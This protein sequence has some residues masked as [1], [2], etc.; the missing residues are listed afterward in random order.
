MTSKT[1]SLGSPLTEGNHLYLNKENRGWKEALN[2]LLTKIDKMSESNSINNTILR[3]LP[4]GDIEMDNIMVGQAYF[5][6]SM[7][8]SCE[9]I[10]NKWNN[11]STFYQQLSTNNKRQFRKNVLRTKHHFEFEVKTEWTEQ[12]SVNYF[13]LYRNVK[14]KSL[15][16]NTFELPIKLFKMSSSLDNWEILSLYLKSEFDSREERKPV[17]MALCHKGQN[18]YSFVL[19]GL[20]YEYNGQHNCYRQLLAK[21]VERGAELNYNKIKLGFTSIIEK[22]R[23]GGKIIESVAYMQVKDNYTLEA[24]GAMSTNNKREDGFNQRRVLSV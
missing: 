1:V 20:D 8:E 19:A 22:K 5:K 15:S 21:I 11:L 24:L 9:I 10:T 23:F 14:N 13:N 17:A 6:M 7:P 3:D 2:L 12:D 16:L 18:D 4:E